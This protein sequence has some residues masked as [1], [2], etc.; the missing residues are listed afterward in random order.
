MGLYPA[1]CQ[2]GT[3]QY[4]VNLLAICAW[5][6]LPRPER[7]DGPWEDTAQ[8]SA[9]GVKNQCRAQHKRWGDGV[10]DGAAVDPDVCW[11]RSAAGESAISE[12]GLL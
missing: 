12:D 8:A 7:P 6:R 3:R 10:G 9:T 5:R 1:A 4:Q 11:G 2:G